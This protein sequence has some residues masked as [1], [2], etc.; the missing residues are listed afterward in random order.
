MRNT[1]TCE[2]SLKTVPAMEKQP[3]SA[4]RGGLKQATNNGWKKSRIFVTGIKGDS[5]IFVSFFSLGFFVSRAFGFTR[6]SPIHL[7]FAMRLHMGMLML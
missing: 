7:F 5:F 2:A 6:S 3:A 4:G 1:A